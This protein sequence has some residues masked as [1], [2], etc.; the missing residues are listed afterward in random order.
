M[1]YYVRLMEKADVASVTQIDHESF[2]S[3][4]PPP[5]YRKELENKLAHYL[6]ACDISRKAAQ[7]EEPIAPPG[8]L[9]YQLKRF[10]NWNKRNESET[11][12]R[13]E[14]ITGYAGFWLMA[15]EAHLV[16]IAVRNNYHRQGIGELLLISVIE[17]ATELKACLVTLEVRESNEGA[18]SLYRKYGFKEVGKRR[19]Y[20][21]DNREDALLM[22]LEEIDSPVFQDHLKILKQT[23]ASRWGAS[24]EP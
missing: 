4:W 19:G 10:F 17:L 8:G 22:T 11:S 1:R 7:V 5:N 3:M 18:Q 23:H 6:V 15:D 12:R 21:T 9:S 2:A 20:Y 14:L 24:Q 13:K 16:S